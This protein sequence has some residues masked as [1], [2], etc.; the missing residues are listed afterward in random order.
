M[1]GYDNTPFLGELERRGFY[2]ARGSLSN[3]RHTELS[4]ATVLNMDYMQAFPEAYDPNSNNR[5]GI[6]AFI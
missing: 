4:I 2:I 5:M 3:Y 1:H 6:V